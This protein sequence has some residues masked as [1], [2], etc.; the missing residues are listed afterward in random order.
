MTNNHFIDEKRKSLTQFVRDQLIGPGVYGYKFGLDGEPETVEILDITP[1][2]LYCSG[3]LFP[4]KKQGGNTTEPDNP[5]IEEGVL[6]TGTRNV[7]DDEDDDQ[8]QMYDEEDIR[9]LTQRY[10]DSFGISC[11]LGKPS[12][13]HNDLRINLSGRF[14]SKIEQD[15]YSHVFVRVDSRDVPSVLNLINFSIQI[16][17]QEPLVCLNEYFSFSENSKLYLRTTAQASYSVIRKILD[18]LSRHFSREIA[19]RLTVP[20]PCYGNP[21]RGMLLQS[22][23]EKVFENLNRTNNNTIERDAKTI[24]LIEEKEAAISYFHDLLPLL[25]YKGYGFWRSRSFAFDLDLSKVD[26]S[27]RI[28]RPTAENGLL[29]IPLLDANGSTIDSPDAK[30]SVW[31]QVIKDSRNDSND[32]TY[33]KVLVENTS[34]PFEETPKNYYSIVTEGVNKKC[35]FGIKID[36]YSDCLEPYGMQTESNLPDIEQDHLQY[37]YRKVKDYGVGHLCSV[38]WNQGQ[39]THV[40]SEFMPSYN[41]PDVDVIPQKIV[42]ENGQGTTTELIS[43]TTCLQFKELSTLSDANNQTIIDRLHYFANTYKAWIDATIV[44]QDPANKEKVQSIRE[45]CM[46]DYLR[47]SSNIAMLAASQN[48]MLSFRLMNTAMFMQ[49]WHSKKDNRELAANHGDF[50]DEDFYRA[51]NPE[52]RTGKGPAAWRPFQLAFILL[53]LDGIVQPRNNPEWRERNDLVDLVWFPTGGGKTEAY[54]GIIAFTILYRRLS[55]RNSSGTTAIMR[56]TLRLLAT[57]QFQR[58]LRLILAL[59]QIRKWE[60]NGRPRYSLGDSVINI[61]LFV[62]G[63]ALPNSLNDQGQGINRTNGLNTEGENWNNGRPSKIPFEEKKCPWCGSEMRWD[64]DRRTVVCENAFCAFSTLEGGAPVLLCD[65]LI[66]STP[67]TLLFGT[68]D[69]FAAIAHKVS[70]ENSSDSRRLFRINALTPDLII[71]DELHL[72]EGPLGSAFGLF[73]NAIDALSTRE[74]A[75][76]LKIRPKVISSTATTRN[77]SFQILALFDRKVN[78]FPKNGVNFDDSFFAFYKRDAQNVNEYDSKRRYIGILPTGRTAMYT[79]IRLAACCFT[80]RALFEEK[81][82]SDLH[83]DL[84]VKAADYYFSLISYFNSKKDVANTSAQ[85]DTEFPKYTRQVFH[86][87]CRQRLMLGCFYA[88]N[89]S[90]SCAELTGRLNGNEVI[91]SLGLV[92]RQWDPDKRIPHP[93]AD[94]HLV[95][96]ETPPDLILAT[97]MIS[98]GIDVSRFN[99]MIINSMPRNK[100]EYIQASS[101]VARDEPGIVFT[102]HNPYRARD[103]SHFEKFREFHEKLY[104]YVDPISVTP[105]SP[106]SIEKYLP[107]VIASIMRHGDFGLSVN[108]DIQSI[109]HKNAEEVKKCILQMFKNRLESIRHKSDGNPLL[110]GI[111]TEGAIEQISSLIDKA[112][113]EW[114]DRKDNLKFFDNNRERESSLFLPLDAYDDEKQTTSWCVPY[115]IRDI[116]ESSVIKIKNN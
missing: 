82:V 84:F 11:C 71:Q 1:G 60:A 79:Q 54:L 24:S 85:F 87:V 51:A 63:D 77:T 34:L 81:H 92:Q 98:V 9:Q 75:N 62:G 7:N 96:G 68:A 15:S 67:P 19:Y 32:N 66:Y 40:W 112:M 22:Y 39:T 115:S 43:D 105:Y 107:L 109:N 103:L 23:K 69:K 111:I 48:A 45:G 116:A 99:L 95:G 28:I 37:I 12:L 44:D 31:L 59:E 53:N 55:N 50:L 35:F 33:L 70:T 56:Y 74:D 73:E 57:Q 38:D 14:Y 29:N 110:S 102:L 88:M 108:S 114:I 5:N 83:D 41:T 61:G 26:F 27:K 76:G 93:N 101:R 2:S 52:I 91:S 3:I 25:D 4:K 58:A 30:L 72:L 78:V 36:I 100:A 20:D 16:E 49:L 94:G 65:E 104:Y 21:A 18:S 42:T 8:S 80:H 64:R 13:C 89:R 6:E 86:R 106:Q 90:F 10:P 46:S 17:E 113:E 47:I 97:N